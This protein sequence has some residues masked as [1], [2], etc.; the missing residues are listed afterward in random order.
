M[1]V[2][3]DGTR[4]GL[5]EPVVD[6]VFSVDNGSNDGGNLLNPYLVVHLYPKV[7][8]NQNVYPNPNVYPKPNVYPYPNVY[9]NPKVY[10][11]P[12]V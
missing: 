10:L 7:Y 6:D 3:A 1:F 11:N 8:P 4:T 2:C 12:Y 9:S 5:L